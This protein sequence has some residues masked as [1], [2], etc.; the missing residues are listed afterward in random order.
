MKGDIGAAGIA[1]FKAIATAEQI[2]DVGG[3]INFRTWLANGMTVNGMADGALKQLEK[4]S[5]LAQRSGFRQMPFQLSIAKIRAIAM[6][7]EPARSARVDEAKR[8]F[9]STLRVAEEEKVYGAEIE[10]LTQRG[11]FAYESGNMGEAEEAF[12]QAAH[13]AKTAELPGLEANADLQLVR[14]YLQTK[15]PEKAAACIRQDM[16]R[17]GAHPRWVRLAPFC[18]G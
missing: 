3:A 1:L 6:L 9:T 13:V 18:G 11:Q 15:Q 17:C 14:V 8:L 16:A 10:L 4:A 12:V 7:P 5:D 2:G